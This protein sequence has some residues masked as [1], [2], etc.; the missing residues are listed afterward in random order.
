M[1]VGNLFIVILI[2]VPIL[3]LFFDNVKIFQVFSDFDLLGIQDI[4][5][6]LH[7]S[8]LGTI[9]LWNE[10]KILRTA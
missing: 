6:I 4:H 2:R 10:A 5:G 7:F 3:I 1:L 8:R 9:I